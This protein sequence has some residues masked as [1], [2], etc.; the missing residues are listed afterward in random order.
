MC[1]EIRLA[2]ISWDKQMEV[3]RR[4]ANPSTTLFHLSHL[5]HFF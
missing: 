4:K 2:P 1:K 5:S 3:G